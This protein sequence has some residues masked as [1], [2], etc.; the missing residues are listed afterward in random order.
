MKKATTAHSLCEADMPNTP[1]CALISFLVWRLRFRV[2]GSGF[3]VQGL[4][5]S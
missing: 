2:P 4:G 3:R 1:G 5:L